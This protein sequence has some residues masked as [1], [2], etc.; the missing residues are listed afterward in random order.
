MI[1]KFTKSGRDRRGPNSFITVIIF[2]EYIT[3][4]E[5]LALH[6]SNPH[7][8]IKRVNLR[9]LCPFLIETAAITMPFPLRPL[10]ATTFP[11]LQLALEAKMKD[12]FNQSPLPP[13]CMT[14]RAGSAVGPAGLESLR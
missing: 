11:F 3:S 9:D 13:L 14:F 5:R 12:H 1:F 2:Q 10:M 6:I 8:I 7:N 4:Q